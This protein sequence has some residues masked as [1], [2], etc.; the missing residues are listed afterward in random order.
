M[1]R[2]AELEFGDGGGIVLF[3]QV[4]QQRLNKW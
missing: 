1:H 3:E 4:R 2:N